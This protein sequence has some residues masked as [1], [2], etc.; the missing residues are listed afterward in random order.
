VSD[1]PNC[2]GQ[3]YLVNTLTT[4]PEMI[5]TPCSD[6]NGTGSV[7]DKEETCHCIG[8]PRRYND[9]NGITR[10]CDHLTDKEET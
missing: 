1:C 2:E 5:G 9:A 4:P 6:C 8:R 3:G 7:T 10:P